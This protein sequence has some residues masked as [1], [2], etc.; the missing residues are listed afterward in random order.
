MAG[1]LALLRVPSLA[2][3]SFANILLFTGGVA[4]AGGVGGVV[5]YATDGLRTGGSW[6]KTLA[7]VLT[8]LVYCFGALVL[9]YL[10]FGPR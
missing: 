8:L 7:N 10:A 9:I 3:E 1:F 4:I 6:R 2:R 5:Y